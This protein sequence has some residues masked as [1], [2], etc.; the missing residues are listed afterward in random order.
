MASKISTLIP[1]FAMTSAAISPAGP[2]PITAALGTASWVFSSVCNAVMLSSGGPQDR[3]PEALK[4]A[5]HDA[6]R[7]YRVKRQQR[8][9][10]ARFPKEYRRDRTEVSNRHEGGQRRLRRAAGQ[11]EQDREQEGAPH[12]RPVPDLGQWRHGG[13]QRMDILSV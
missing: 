1:V 10:E 11:P 4:K 3:P 7:D 8:Q 13:H 6:D 2:P 12:H 9:V 5:V